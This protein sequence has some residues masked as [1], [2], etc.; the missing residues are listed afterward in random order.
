MAEAGAEVMPEGRPCAGIVGRKKQRGH[1]NQ[2]THAGGTHENAENQRDADR[3]NTKTDVTMTPADKVV[4]LNA[5]TQ[6]AGDKGVRIDMDVYVPRNTDL[7]ITSR[8]GDVNIAGVNGNVEIN[9]QRGEVNLNDHTGNATLSI[10]RGSAR[11]Q[12]MKGDLTVQGSANEVA[13]ED[14]DGAVRL[15]GE[16]WD[17]VRLVRVSKTVTFRSSRTDMEFSRLDG[18]LDLDPRDLRADSLTGPMHLTT[19][20]KDI[21]L[22][23]LSGDLRLENSNGTV[24]VGLY[25]P[26]NIQIDNRKGDIQVSIP[27]NTAVKV[28]ARTREGDI[29]SDF[30]EVKVE[31]GEKQATANGSIGS[32]GPHLILNSDKGS[33][34]IRKG[35]VAA[36]PPAPPALPA[37]PGKPAKALPAPKAAPVESEN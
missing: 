18:R 28:E 31:N 17:S 6:G 13:V 23:G 12:H 26:G 7:V 27:P 33:I 8:R 2:A 16:F 21:S 25:K 15:N 19:R 9:H 32:N 3:Y 10:E 37:K 35:T 29:E 14:V 4:V 30:G 22:E 5:N 1:V 34:E 36:A 20:S 11:V 24:A